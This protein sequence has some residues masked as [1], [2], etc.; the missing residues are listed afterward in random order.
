MMKSIIAAVSAALALGVATAG[1]AEAGNWTARWTGPRGGVYE[2]SGSCG[3]GACQ[4][5]GTFTGPNGGVWH[6][7]GNS[8]QV[9]PGEWAGE[10]S[11]VG[12]GG[13][14]WQNSWTWRAA[15]K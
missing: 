14:T 11:I 12:P 10:H 8:H 9:A 3:N 2:G 6:H 7:T 13:N 15:G 1:A 5:S 4:S